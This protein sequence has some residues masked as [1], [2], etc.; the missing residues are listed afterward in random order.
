MF[1]MV[2]DTSHLLW[3]ENVFLVHAFDL[4]HGT[5]DGVKRPYPEWGMVRNGQAVMA[6]EICFQNH[7]ADFLINPPIAVMFA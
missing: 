7:M 1:S 3:I 6:G 2:G 5:E 4:G